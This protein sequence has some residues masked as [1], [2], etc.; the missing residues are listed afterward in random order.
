MLK[1]LAILSVLSISSIVHA[2]ILASSTRIVFDEG[3]SQKSVMLV[4]TNDYPVFTQVWTDDG[5]GN[6]DY[7]DSP[8]VVVPAAFNLKPQE[9]KGV[10]IIYNKME[11]PS[12]RESVYWL[13]LYE[14]PAVTKASLDSDYL[15][16]AMNTQMKIFYRPN[17]LKNRNLIDIQK[18]LKFSFDSVGNTV[19]IKAENPTP[20]YISIMSIKL[21]NQGA[22]SKVSHATE[23]MI[24]PFSNKV[25]SLENHEFIK[26]NKNTLEYILIDDDG[27]KVTF[28]QDL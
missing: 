28:S 2:G 22:S 12:D 5:E 13:N 27:Q 20:Y 17:V 16:L 8:F 6:P 14:I 21:S 25:Y 23:N 3:M 19:Q 24:S 26:E 4:N 9:I 18:K 10:N 11:L 1:K 15:N 7:T